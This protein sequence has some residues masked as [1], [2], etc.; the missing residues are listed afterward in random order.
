[1]CITLPRLRLQPTSLA[2]HYQLSLYIEAPCVR[3][4]SYHSRI[5]TIMLLRVLQRLAVAL[6]VSGSLSTAAQT[7]QYNLRSPTAPSAL[8]AGVTHETTKLNGFNI[9]ISRLQFS[10]Y[11]LTRIRLSTRHAHWRQIPGHNLSCQCIWELN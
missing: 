8:P 1:L 6:A 3:L 11:Q 9:R 7:D 2:P 4:K 5:E 10:P